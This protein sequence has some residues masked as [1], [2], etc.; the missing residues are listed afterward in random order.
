MQNTH[1]T[2]GMRIKALREAKGWDIF[3]LSLNA[4]VREQTLRTWEEGRRVPND[5]HMLARVAA[6]LGT[7]TD[8]L[9]TGVA[10]GSKRGAA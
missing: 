2:L 5:I 3:T 7:T 1:E 9:I 4:E 8:Y 6:A 10:P